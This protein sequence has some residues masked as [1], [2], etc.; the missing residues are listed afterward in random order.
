M[1]SPRGPVERIV[2]LRPC[3]CGMTPERLCVEGDHPRPKWARVSGQCCNSWSIEYR[4]N[5]AVLDTAEADQ[6]AMAAWNAAPRA[7]ANA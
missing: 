6:V 7:Q 4:N 5:Y 3:P 1:T 2:S